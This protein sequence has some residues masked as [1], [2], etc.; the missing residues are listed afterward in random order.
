MS[1]VELKDLMRGYETMFYIREAQEQLRDLYLRNKIFSMVHF[2][3]GQEAVASGVCDALDLHD[4]VLGNHRSHGH[5]LAKGGNFRKLA[6]ELFGKENGASRGK[7]GSMHL[8]DKSV[9]F[10]GSSPLLGS[11]VP[12]ATGVAFAQKFINQPGITVVFYGDGASE[13]GVVYESYN[14]AAL[15]ETP[16]LFVLENN[17]H[18]INSKLS[19]RRSLGYDV[20]KISEGLGIGKYKK[21]DGNDYLSVSRDAADLIGYIRKTGKPA[22]LECMTYRH[23]A[24]STPLME[25]GYRSEDSLVN[26]VASD[27]V[28]NLKKIILSYGAE[29]NLIKTLEERIRASISEDIE[30]ALNS[31]EPNKCELFNN[32]FN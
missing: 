23:L 10:I 26:R 31:K 19:E 12:I 15:Y 5:Y 20:S 9:N 8:I 4:K 11:A 25:E 32:V 21:T 18:S 22:I 28:L 13:E 16:I 14:L 7:G 27:P 2:Y 17:F 3:I 6:S 1:N 30:F 29:L 24:H